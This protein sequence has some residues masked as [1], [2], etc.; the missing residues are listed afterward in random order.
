MFLQFLKLLYQTNL[1]FGLFFIE[2][3]PLGSGFGRIPSVKLLLT[4]N[5]DR[6]EEEDGTQGGVGEVDVCCSEDVR[7]VLVRESG[8]EDI[9]EASLSLVSLRTEPVFFFLSDSSR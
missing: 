1:T 7:D 5:W 6:G 4:G 3:N 2:A 9:G 8:G